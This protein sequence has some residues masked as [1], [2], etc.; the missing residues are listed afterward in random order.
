MEKVFCRMNVSNCDLLMRVA[1]YVSKAY[2]KQAL[3]LHDE[4]KVKLAYPA[5]CKAEQFSNIFFDVLHKNAESYPFMKSFR[6][7]SKQ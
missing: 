5:V 1:W 7:E 6:E 3:S 2:L 4:K